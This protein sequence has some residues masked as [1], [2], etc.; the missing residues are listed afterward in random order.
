MFGSTRSSTCAHIFT[1]TCAFLRWQH[2]GKTYYP[3]DRMRTGTADAKP[4][5]SS[6]CGSFGLDRRGLDRRGCRCLLR[7]YAI[8]PSTAIGCDSNQ[9]A[10][11]L[12]IRR[13][14]ML[15]RACCRLVNSQFLRVTG[16]RLV[17]VL[18]FRLVALERLH[19]T[20]QDKTH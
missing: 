18:I 14:Q 16:D 17:A 8:D 20:S 10:K 6:L 2:T 5:I 1:V 4:D 11:L 12:L 3:Y 9:S 7:G 13:I 19:C 15:E